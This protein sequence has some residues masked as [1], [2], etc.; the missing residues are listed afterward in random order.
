MRGIAGKIAIVTGAAGMGGIGRAIALRLAQEGAD[1]AVTDIKRLPGQIPAEEVTANWQGIHSVAREIEAL[2]RRSLPVYANI[3]SS[4]EVQAM[5]EQVVKR[6]GRL[7]IMVNNARA[8]FGAD[9][10]LMVELEESELERV[11]AVN[12]KG[13]FLCCKAAALEMIKQQDGGTIINISSMAGKKAVPRRGAYS[14]SKFAIMGLTQVLALELAPHGIRVNA[15]CPGLVDS[16]RVNPNE[17]MA[18]EREGIP[19]EV[20]CARRIKA[21]GAQIPLGVASPGDV[22]AVAAFLASTDSNRLTGEAINAT[23]GELMD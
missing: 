14:T 22:A 16:G 13:T 15:I 4:T 2:G 21:R 23:G 6:F 12:V 8:Q 17:K 7:D 18:A 9:Q 11:L 1:V 3:A 20:Y 10:V 19:V 5:V